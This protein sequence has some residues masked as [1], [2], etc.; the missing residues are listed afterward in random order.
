MSKQ[1]RL[2]SNPLAW[3]TSTTAVKAEAAAKA[4]HDEASPPAVTEKTSGAKKLVLNKR[5]QKSNPQSYYFMPFSAKTTEALGR[6]LQDLLSWLEEEGANERIE[7][8][9]YTLLIGRSHFNQ[10]SALLVSDIVELKSSLQTILQTGTAPS[11]VTKPEQKRKAANDAE[12]VS[13]GNEWLQ[14]LANG[15]KSAEEE[16]SVLLQVA[17]LYVQGAAL[18]W[19]L[20]AINGKRISMPTYPFAKERFWL[21]ENV[22]KPSSFATQSVLRSSP[23]DA[24]TETVLYGIDWVSAPVAATKQ[25]SFYRVLV[26]EAGDGYSQHVRQRMQSITGL[27]I[28]VI[29]VHAGDSYAELGNG[30]IRIRTDAADDYIRLFESLKAQNR[31][32]ELLLNFWPFS[33]AE[34]DRKSQLSI[35]VQVYFHLVRALHQLSIQTL[36]R[37]L[38]L[39]PSDYSNPASYHEAVGGYSRSLQMVQPQL[40][41]SVIGAQQHK[42]EDLIELSIQEALT[43]FRDLDRE[44]RYN[45]KLRTVRKAQRIPMNTN[46]G[47]DMLKHQ[48]VYLITGGTGGLGLLFAEEL[49]VQYK[50]RLALI[51][52]SELDA[53]RQLKIDAL[54]GLG[55]DVIYI[56]GDVGSRTD[57][58]KAMET[59]KERWGR[60]DG[61]LH[62]AGQMEGELVLHKTEEK[63]A[64]IMQPKIEGTVLLDELTSGEELDFFA[65]FSSTS[66]YLGDI[67]QCD[68]AIGNRFL[69]GYAAYREELRSQGKRSGQTLSINWPIWRDGGMHL[70]K[71]AEELYLQASGM[72]YLEK[73]AG[74]SAFNQLLRSGRCQ[75]MVLA[76]NRERMERFLQ[77]EELEPP[78]AE[79]A[80]SPVSNEESMIGT[81]RRLLFDLKQIAADYVKMPPEK[82]DLEENLG[83]YG[84]DS[85]DLKKLA[86]QLSDYF[87]ISVSPTVFFAHSSLQSISEHLLDSFG[88]SIL[89]HYS[90]LEPAAAHT[91]K[92]PAL[93]QAAAP[94]RKET[95]NQPA[96]VSIAPDLQSIKEPVAIIGVHGIFPQSNGLDEFWSHL[97]AEK[98]LIT[99]IPGD[100]WNYRDFYK[101]GGP[102]KG[103]QNT[104]W[105]GFIR[106][107]DKFDPSFFHI[108]PREAELID[109]QHRLFLESVW[110]TIENAGYRSSSLE[111][112]NIGVFVGAQFTD[113]H[114]L[115]DQ[116]GIFHANL[117]TGNAHT[118][119]PNR[120]SYLMDWHGPSESIDTACSSSLVAV[121]RAVKSIQSGESELA[122]AGG[123]SLMLNPQTL[124]TISQ[125]GVLSPDGRC[126]TFDTR[127]NGYVRGEGVGSILLKPLSKA[128]A[129]G[130]HIYA[131]IKGSAENHGG[132]ANSLTAPNSEAQASVLLRAYE[133]AGVDPEHITYIETHGTGTELGDPVEIEGLKKAFRDLYKRRGQTPAKRNYC[134]LGSL[135]TNIGHLEPASGI[136][137]ILKVVL[138]IR[139]QTLPGTVHFE[140]KNPYIEIDDS[141][142]YI[143]D[144][145]RSWTTGLDAAGRTIP[146]IAAVSS[147]G[148]GGTNAHVVIE[149]FSHAAQ[150]VPTDEPQV[151]VLSAKTEERLKAYAADLCRFLIPGKDA[152][153]ESVLPQYEARELLR[154]DLAREL[155]GLIH[156]QAQEI[157]AFE[158]FE[159]L[160]GTDSMVM[161]QFC[162]VVGSR[163]GL[164][165]KVDWLSEC[166]SLD[167]LAG[168]M[169]AE[170]QAS[171]YAFYDKGLPRQD[172]KEAASAA[173]ESVHSLADLAYTLQ[174]GREAMDERLAVV[175]SSIEELTKKLSAYVQDRADERAVLRGNITGQTR[176]SFLD[177][178][179]GK[180]FIA[181][182]QQNRE[183]NK[184]AELWTLGI[185]FNW[186]LIHG[187][188]DPKRVPAPTYPFARERYWLPNASGMKGDA[189]AARLHPMLERNTSTFHEQKFTTTLR[190]NEFY[191]ADHTVAGCQV[192]PGV[193]MI[194]MARK[195]GELATVSSVYKLGNLLWAQPV[196]VISGSQQEI[197]M[198]LYINEEDQVE[199]ELFTI[200]ADDRV[201]H[202]Q[203]M[204]QTSEEEARQVEAFLD[205]EELRNRLDGRMSGEACYQWFKEIG[206]DYGPSFRIVQDLWHEGHEALSMLR[207]PGHLQGDFNEW[208]LHPSLLDGALHTISSLQD[209]IEPQPLSLPFALDEVEILRPLVPVCYAY[210][211]LT[212]ADGRLKKYDITITDEMGR[213]LVQMKQ[214]AVKPVRGHEPDQRD[215]L[216]KLFQKLQDGELAVNEVEQLTGRFA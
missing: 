58:T 55:A 190:G 164:D 163:Y 64:S 33:N 44:V 92:Q 67:G 179:A 30:I 53:K 74:L 188:H 155:S 49:A 211:K 18:N 50:A 176:L 19:G 134:G 146:R 125:L 177:G 47:L 99:E 45:N 178:E 180:Q 187:G 10:R 165:M 52:R 215:Q 32:P 148:F 65:L 169:M 20:M 152:A 138:A 6:R 185:D 167:K 110:K 84:F 85:I 139:H 17:E 212:A 23:V 117:A 77:I 171:I 16:E 38:H 159:E 144:K 78:I 4:K 54:R 56:Q 89:M 205:L 116:Q 26:M 198:S 106:D 174:T 140:Q 73:E 186:Q 193:A 181:M 27:T 83:N 162:R 5:T 124:T 182:V 79:T 149:E 28:D 114:Q 12:T 142:F 9:A 115:L 62:A 112:R 199:F 166:S 41:L 191:I 103:K 22:R 147:F 151:I 88:D 195:A 69:D 90:R 118:M 161:E 141:P 51:G 15:G 66:A 108:S 175:A 207:L 42:I 14:Q 216:L 71:E 94:A 37:L 194:E 213:V 170:H 102:A 208:G 135:K 96:G 113:Y 40:Q 143:I 43:P 63:F 2:G 97:K 8:I 145:T 128:Q 59:V 57:L 104:K 34:G 25:P 172:E 206:L 204:L 109:P 46:G 76:G 122:V 131:V 29:T 100:R 168:R 82:M 107:A 91:P 127:A 137:G 130:D 173:F 7:D 3:L 35:G 154:G 36:K 101:E 150:R 126:R 48:G 31:L 81:E 203:G 75:G 197:N 13:R 192:L 214:F 21:P 123:V 183:M 136:A 70:S 184:L 68:Y 24:A 87:R 153:M 119:L 120:V 39:Y 11:Y 196:E 60:V 86:K 158:A 189:A 121:H 98:D 156:V 202:A 61:V 95:F 209:G 200:S 93:Q 160:V 133:E 1:P 157:E 132:K 105:G 129:D 111:G 72:S 80:V 210:M 201:V